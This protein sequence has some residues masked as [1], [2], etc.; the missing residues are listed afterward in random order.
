MSRSK[1]FPRAFTLVELLAVIAIIAILVA[2]LL[3]YLGQARE[4]A[5]RAR[6]RS[7]MKALIP[8]ALTYANYYRCLA[9]IGWGPTYTSGNYSA[10]LYLWYEKPMLGQFFGEDVPRD[11]AVAGWSPPKKSVLRCPT[12]AAWPEIDPQSSWIAYNSN[13]AFDCAPLRA[14]SENGPKC[15]W[16]GPRLDEIVTGSHRFVLFADGRGGSV[17]YI[18]DTAYCDG[19]YD[20]SASSATTDSR[21]GG[22]VN[23]GFLDG[24]VSYYPNAT[25]AHFDRFVL[26]SHR[27]DNK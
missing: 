23:F 14:D 7:N 25:Q 26:L 11:G 4:L 16:R 18:G 22:G 19:S 12:R 8:A 27:S 2:I 10:V 6:C 1:R 17:Y 24:H 21:H 3:P 13:M 5:Y 15:F 9:P 20:I